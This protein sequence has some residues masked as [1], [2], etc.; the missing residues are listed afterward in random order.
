MGAIK[1]HLINGPNRLKS[2]DCGI[3]DSSAVVELNGGNRTM[4]CNGTGHLRP[5]LYRLLTENGMPGGGKAP[6][7]HRRVAY[8]NLRHAAFGLFLIIAH[9]I[10]RG[11][12][13]R[14]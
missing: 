13:V 4:L 11:A 2:G 7:L 12:S 10:V 5:F 8:G 9:H 1:L 14:I 6:F 3:G